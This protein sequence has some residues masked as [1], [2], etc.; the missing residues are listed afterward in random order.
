MSDAP[1]WQDFFDAAK[2]EMYS[3]RPDLSWEEGD[4][5]EMI[6][7]GIGAVG[8]RLVGWAAEEFRN[9]YV[10]GAK[11]ARLTALGNDHWN[12]AR[13]GN[14]KAVGT[15]TITRSV[16]ALEAGTIDAGSIVATGQAADGSEVQYATSAPQV[17]SGS[18]TGS[19]DAAVEAVEPGRAGNVGAGKVTRIISALFDP[20]FTVTNA[21]RMAGGTEP[22]TDESYREE[23]RGFAATMRRGTLDAIEYGA[24]QVSGVVNATAADLGPAL[25]SLYVS[26][27]DGYSNAAML[28]AV[29][30]AMTSW[31][32]AGITVSVYGGTPYTLTI[33]IT[34]TVKAGFDTAAIAYAAKLAIVARLD[35][36]RIGENCTRDMIKQAAMNVS[37]GITACN[38][39]VPA[40]D[41]APVAAQVIR[42]AVGNITVA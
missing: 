36:L 38:V 17:W 24:K 29:N 7:S 20:T 15:V 23:I 27:V 16:G 9:T 37:T 34:L 22:Q 1:S 30:V 11:A 25:V 8:D 26:D 3:V 42:T 31:R 19:K 12:L 32:A 13:T 21:E 2:A 6:A 14:D 33:S 39:T 28:A 40:T 35:K 4:I 41:V 5:T 10:D 18:E